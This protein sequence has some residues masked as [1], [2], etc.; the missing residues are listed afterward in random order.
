MLQPSVMPPPS[1]RVAKATL[2]QLCREHWAVFWHRPGHDLEAEVP[3]GVAQRLGCGDPASGYRT[4][5]G[6]RW[7]AEKQVALSCQSSVCLSC[8]T[9]YSDPW[10]R[11]LGQTLYD[12]VS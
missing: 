10:G 12:G 3:E 7:L 4:D 2:Q 6:E 9:M 5:L 11:H 8:C 1:T